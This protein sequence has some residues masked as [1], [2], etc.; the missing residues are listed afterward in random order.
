M[1]VNFVIT[2]KDYD[3]AYQ[4][5]KKHAR[6]PRYLSK[7]WDWVAFMSLMAL[8]ILW[9]FAGP[10]LWE[11][12]SLAYTITAIGSLLLVLLLGLI[13][14]STQKPQWKKNRLFNL[15]LGE[16]AV[17][18]LSGEGLTIELPEGKRRLSW[19]RITDLFADYDYI[20]IGEGGEKFHL[21]PRRA[22]PAPDRG[23]TFIKAIMENIPPDPFDDRPGSFSA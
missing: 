22:F 1:E 3:W 21:I 10:I 17:Y 7:N 6:L 5:L 18:K 23:E 9:V 16:S 20:L 2:Q 14:S 11:K 15:H 19:S 8:F 4:L 12:N 13:Y